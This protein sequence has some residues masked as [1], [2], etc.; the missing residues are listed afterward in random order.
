M[1]AAEDD[2]GWLKVRR[3]QSPFMLTAFIRKK[4]GHYNIGE[5]SIVFAILSVGAVFPVL[6]IG[7]CLH[8]LLGL[9]SSITVPTCLLLWL[10]FVVWLWISFV[11][12][13]RECPDGRLSTRE[14]TVMQL[15]CLVFVG[16]HALFASPHER[17]SW[18]MVGGTFTWVFVA[19]HLIYFTLA[20][21]MRARVPLRTYLM[22]T[23]IIGFVWWR[24]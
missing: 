4:A 2:N 11:L 12:V 18:E 9:S 19:L 6:I 23:L 20:W 3:V 15:L 5:M 21:A 17:Q 16:A 13:G 24:F 14:M 22:A 10:G 1:G 8:Y 7:M